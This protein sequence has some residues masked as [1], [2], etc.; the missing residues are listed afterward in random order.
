MSGVG[1]SKSNRE[2]MFSKN[3]AADP[4]SYL[5]SSIT[6]L[7]NEYKMIG[8]VSRLLAGRTHHPFLKRSAGF[9]AACSISASA[10]TVSKKMDAVSA[11]FIG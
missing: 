1:T 6:L 7:L 11:K 2:G 3:D 4:Q 9:S 8:T 5:L 10:T